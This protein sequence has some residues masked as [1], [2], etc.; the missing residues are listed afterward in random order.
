MQFPP[1]LVYCCRTVYKVGSV[2]PKT[3]SRY[4]EYKNGGGN[5]PT[6]VLPSHIRRYGSAFLN[7]SGGKLCIGV[8]DNGM[9][10]VCAC[11]SM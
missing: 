4:V 8:A 10:S 2:L 1:P 3:E 11:M 6:T 9:Y 5:Y 7:S